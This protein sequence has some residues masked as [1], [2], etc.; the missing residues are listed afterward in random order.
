M[1]NS[2]CY[3]PFIRFSSVVVLFLFAIYVCVCTILLFKCKKKHFMKMSCIDYIFN[4]CV[5]TKFS[6]TAKVVLYLNIVHLSI[7]FYENKYK[8]LIFFLIY[9]EFRVF[10]N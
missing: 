2:Q 3:I 6:L 9:L 4:I 5:C 7:T 1:L 8:T 10:S